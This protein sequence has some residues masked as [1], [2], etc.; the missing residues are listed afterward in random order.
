M[1][2]ILW[3]KRIKAIVVVILNEIYFLLQI[4]KKYKETLGDLALILKEEPKNKAAQ[5]EMDECKDLYR[6][7]NSLIVWLFCVEKKTKPLG[8]SVTLG[9]WKWRYFLV[10]KKELKELQSKASNTSKKGK[11]M[12]IE[13][14]TSEVFIYNL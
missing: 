14:V 11:K 2:I 10:F 4:L 8:R 3:K 7:V 6:A 13:E 9:K 5:K 12:K 1:I